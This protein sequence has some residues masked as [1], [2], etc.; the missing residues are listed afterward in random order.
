ML[1]LAASDARATL[2]PLLVEAKARLQAAY[3]ALQHAGSALA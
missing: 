3:Q 2:E 1:S